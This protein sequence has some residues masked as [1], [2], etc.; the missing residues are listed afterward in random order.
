M[1]DALTEFI[2]TNIWGMLLWGIVANLIFAV[3]VA[4][5]RIMAQRVKTPIVKAKFWVLT[6]FLRETAVLRVLCIRYLK[7]GRHDLYREAQR[8][9]EVSWL[10]IYVILFALGV[11]GYFGEKYFG[12][13]AY[14]VTIPLFL[15]AFAD[16]QRRIFLYFSVNYNW[17]SIA[18]FERDRLALMAASKETAIMGA[19]MQN[20]RDEMDVA[21]EIRAAT[22][23]NRAP[24]ANETEP[25]K[26]PDK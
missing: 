19:C 3:A 14:F 13:Y 6:W 17:E 5:V 22:R 20:I 4:V 10:T 18:I 23:N 15:V 2:K 25:P 21:W 16:I 1:Y 7:A 9:S 8:Y 26:P 11:V 12:G 24:K